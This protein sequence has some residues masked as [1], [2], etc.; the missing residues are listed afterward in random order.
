MRYYHEHAIVSLVVMIFFGL[1]KLDAWAYSA[2]IGAMI[3]VSREIRD[4]EKL[5][6]WDMKGFDWEGL[7]W[8]LLSCFLLLFLINAFK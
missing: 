3:Y 1:L 4:V 7:L 5:H 8:P 2:C 6:D